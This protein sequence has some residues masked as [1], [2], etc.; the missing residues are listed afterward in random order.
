M[1]KVKKYMYKGELRTIRQIY[2]MEKPDFSWH[3]FYTRVN[4]EG[5]TINKAL[6]TPVK[7]IPKGKPNWEGL[8]N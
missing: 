1:S 6:F 7:K 3:T 8:K 2:D 4:R 5:W